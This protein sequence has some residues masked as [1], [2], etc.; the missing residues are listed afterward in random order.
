MTVQPSFPFSACA[1]WVCLTNRLKHITRSEEARPL[2]AL[3]PPYIPK[4]L[5]QYVYDDELHD[6]I[7]ATAVGEQGDVR[8]MCLHYY[9][10]ISSS[11]DQSSAIA[12]MA[13]QCCTCHFVL[14]SSTD[15]H[16]V[17]SGTVC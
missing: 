8:I 5:V 17:W 10:R 12:G 2:I 6:W 4:Q 13:A 3:R 16:A 7:V 14:L 1:I 11:I 15:I 9:L